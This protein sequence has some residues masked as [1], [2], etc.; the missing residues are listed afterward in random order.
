MGLLV[1]CSAGGGQL[2]FPVVFNWAPGGGRIP[3]LP[4]PSHLSSLLYVFITPLMRIMS[5]QPRFTVKRICAYGLGLPRRITSPVRL[6]AI[7]NRGLAERR[8]YEYV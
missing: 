1:I 4:P 6:E 2:V 3:T 8:L 7:T 5:R